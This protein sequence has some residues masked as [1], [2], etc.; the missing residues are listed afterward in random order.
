MTADCLEL[1]GRSEELA[2]L[3]GLLAGAADGKGRAALIIGEPGIGKS[4]LVEEFVSG[5]RKEKITILSGRVDEGSV[6]PFGLFSEALS[7]ITG[8]DLFSEEEY[9]GFCSIFLVGEDGALLCKS[10]DEG[11]D[12]DVFAGMLSAVQSFVR[13]SFGG[14]ESAG[15]GK[16]VYGDMA[17][18]IEHGPGFFITGVVRGKEHAGMRQLLGSI[19]K[20]LADGRLCADTPG[21]TQSAIDSALGARFL[22]RKDMESL[23]FGNERIRIAECAAERLAS[24][25]ESQTVLIHLEDVHWADD[26]SLFLYAYLARNIANRRV[27]LL[28]T[29]RPEGRPEFGRLRDSL[30]DEEMAEEITL[31]GLDPGGTRAL[32]DSMLSP[33]EIPDG[34]VARIC[35]ESGGNPL[36]IRE[37]LR[38]MLGDSGISLEMG[39]Y[40]IAREDYSLPE[41]LEGI[42]RRR[43]DTLG[44]EDLAV[45]EYSA[46]IGLRFSASEAG[47]LANL[48]DP[49]PAI[50]RLRVSGI[51][52][53]S[54]GCFEFSHAMFRQVAYSG[55]SGRWKAIYHRSLGEFYEKSRDP[56][57]HIY[58][59][60]R[61]FSLT[62]EHRKAFDYCLKAGERAEGAYAVELAR[63][64]Y[65]SALGML[66]KMGG[67]QCT[68]M[69]PALLEK[70]ADSE[71]GLGLMPDALLHYEAAVGILQEGSAAQLSVLT[72]MAGLLVTLNDTERAGAVLEKA[73]PFADSAPPEIACQI[74]AKYSYIMMTRGKREEAAGLCGEALARLAEV[75]SVGVRVS[76]YN[77]LGKV[78]EQI[79]PDESALRMHQTAVDEAESSGDAKSI[80]M[81][82]SAIGGY[83]HFRGE[84]LAA[85]RLLEKSARYLE[86]LGDIAA[87]AHN[88]GYLGMTYS[89]C[90]ELEKSLASLKRAL[91]LARKIGNRHSIAS[92]LG[93]IGYTL[94]MMGRHE[95]SLA[96][97]AESLDIRKKLDIKDGQAWSHFDMSLVHIQ[98]GNME[99]T[100]GCLEMAASLFRE[101]EDFVG[102]ACA[103]GNMADCYAE[104]GDRGLAER[105]YRETLEIADGRN[106]ASEQ[107]QALMGLAEIGAADSEAV[108]PRLREIT[109]RLERLS[110]SMRLERYL[111]DL[112][113][114]EGDS[115]EAERRYSAGL[116]MAAG[117]PSMEAETS[118]AELLLSRA[119]LRLAEG[120]EKLAEADASES[121]GLY[122]KWGRLREAAKAGNFSLH[123]Q[124]KG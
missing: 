69:R 88:L 64:F 26:S 120:D 72:K 84:H 83:M 50:E 14:G 95:E 4:R 16:L 13:D 74:M 91:L 97:Q 41:S 114:G 102:L 82:Y 85:S 54:G 40:I 58:E 116:A 71:R 89:D 18:L 94:A 70:L 100:L 61:H 12:A 32:V 57:E 124:G 38:Q 63:E 25:A 22:V 23:V 31:G 68:E 45:A 86:K 9:T 76:V 66:P 78:Y 106:L 75:R 17:I 7:G 73:L 93:N 67:G 28:A 92:G 101:S 98:M 44:P 11:L 15:L 59:L 21:K 24:M 6:R 8:H 117:K 60:A 43:L 104:I 119:M 122:M 87:L 62:G 77:S 113:A 90:G 42:I 1:A 52:A 20:A 47:S 65:S 27:L 48:G 115:E 10:G 30:R 107:F 19:A 81:A 79:G 103:K 123:G 29:A 111:G 2:L 110:I 56:E 5:A 36:F 3:R 99:K 55:I 109:G 34:F 96:Y 51:V 121:A 80:A 35:E 105:L 37:T 46:C 53:V 118:A 112:A 39:N 108:L 49:G 33:N